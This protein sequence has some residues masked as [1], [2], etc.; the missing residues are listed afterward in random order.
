MSEVTDG[1]YGEKGEGERV[2]KELPFFVQYL[3]KKKKEGGGKGGEMDAV[4]PQI[5]KDQAL[6]FSLR[7]ATKGEGEEGMRR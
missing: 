1:G 4:S 7:T 3:R 5:K 2:V 6:Y